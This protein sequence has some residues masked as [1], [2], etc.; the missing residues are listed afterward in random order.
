VLRREPSIDFQSAHTVNL[1]SFP[2]KE[3]LRLA[4]AHCRGPTFLLANI[5]RNEIV[6]SLLLLSADE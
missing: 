2:D 4:N 1:D 6:L 3:V 5:W